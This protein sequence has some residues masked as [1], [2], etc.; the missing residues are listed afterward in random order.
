M[1]GDQVVD[2]LTIGFEG[3]EGSLFIG[4]HQPTVTL[5]VGREDRGQL[6]SD[7][8]LGHGAISSQ[9]RGRREILLAGGE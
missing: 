3:L 8:L 4:G 9:T 6:A 7:A 5:D 2:D 1:L